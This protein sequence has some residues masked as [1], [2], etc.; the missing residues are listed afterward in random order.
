MSMLALFDLDEMLAEVAEAPIA[1][2]RRV[3]DGFTLG[4]YPPSELAHAYEAWCKEHGR[5]DSI[6]LSRMWK[7]DVMDSPGETANGHS[8]VSFEADLRRCACGIRKGCSCVGALV[9]R[10]MCEPCSWQAFGGEYAAIAAWH[11]HAWPGW[12]DLPVLPEALRPIGGGVGAGAME[13]SLAKKARAWLE[14]AYP[15]EFQIGGAPMVTSRKPMFSRCV[16]GYSP[17]GGF[18]IAAVDPSEMKVAA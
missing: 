8:L 13:K 5:L 9:Q 7:L 11:D 15:V 12:R 16:S 6:A 3:P 18:D 1:D 17:W 2:G 10:T 4:Y 14:E